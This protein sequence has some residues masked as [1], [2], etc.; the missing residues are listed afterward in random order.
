V[1]LG[2]G[3]YS[4]SSGQVRILRAIQIDT[5]LLTYLLTYK[6]IGSRSRSQEQTCVRG[7]SVFD[8]NAIL[9]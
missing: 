9:L 5:Y 2:P 8:R 7:W 4:E 3:P 6:V 1:N